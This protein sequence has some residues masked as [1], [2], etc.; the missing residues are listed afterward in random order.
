MKKFFT[1]FFFLTLIAAFDSCKENDPYGHLP[2]HYH[3][4]TNWNGN[5]INIRLAKDSTFTFTVF[6]DKGVTFCAAGT[7]SR[8]DSFLFLTSYD[9]THPIST[10]KHFPELKEMNNLVA[11]Q[12]EGK[13]IVRGDKLH[14]LD[15]DGKAHDTEFY[16]KVQ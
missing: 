14:N 11:I 7:W 6:S 1:A 13:F 3:S 8:K 15:K 5:D 12:M 16:D 4:H 9:T 2:G 10:E